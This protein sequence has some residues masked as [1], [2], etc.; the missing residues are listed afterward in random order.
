MRYGSSISSTRAE[1][2]RRARRSGVATLISDVVALA[3]GVAA[4]ASEVAVAPVVCLV[5]G[6]SFVAGL[7][8]EAEEAFAVS[9][10]GAAARTRA[11]KAV[12]SAVR[13]VSSPSPDQ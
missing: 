1:R 13:R 2:Y 6:T 8:E 5:A 4:L 7:F 9:F 10:S 12:L 3:S 11:M